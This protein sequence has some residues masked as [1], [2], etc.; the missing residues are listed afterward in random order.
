M[1]GHVTSTIAI[2]LYPSQCEFL[3]GFEKEK[4]STTD[5][6]MVTGLGEIKILGVITLWAKLKTFYGRPTLTK[7]QVLQKHNGT[8]SI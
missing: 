8:W 7:F 6:I 4:V 5:K 2:N 1:E 3:L